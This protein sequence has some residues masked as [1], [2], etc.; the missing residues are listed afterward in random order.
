MHG[1]DREGAGNLN[2]SKKKPYEI[3]ASQGYYF[4]VPKDAETLDDFVKVADSFMYHNKLEN[5]KNRGES[6]R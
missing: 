2:D 1:R 6:L 5:K 3:H 4:E